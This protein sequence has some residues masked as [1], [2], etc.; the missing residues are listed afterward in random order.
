MS[1]CAY[2]NSLCV[3]VL[4]SNTF[5]F[6]GSST[7]NLKREEELEVKEKYLYYVLYYLTDS[8]DAKPAEMFLLTSKLIW[9]GPEYI[10]CKG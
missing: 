6:M 9:F 7:E 5:I 2:K 4:D 8:F 1:G 3:L 10:I